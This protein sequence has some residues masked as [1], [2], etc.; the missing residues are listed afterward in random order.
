MNFQLLLALYGNLC[1]LDIGKHHLNDN[2]NIESK[3]LLPD[4]L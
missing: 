2:F 1:F 3:V 4:Q